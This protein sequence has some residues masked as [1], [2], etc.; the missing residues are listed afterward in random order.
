VTAGFAIAAG[1]GLGLLAL[2]T[3]L[4]VLLGWFGAWRI[5]R[6]PSSRPDANF[7]FTPWE[8]DLEFSPVH[9]KTA[10]DVRLHGWFLPRPDS[11]RVIIVM[12]GYRG[13]KAQL[14]GISSY[15]WRAGFN[16]LLFD[17]RGRGTSD[18]ANISM[19]LWEQEDLKAA[20]EVADQ[21]VPRAA[22]GLLGYSMGGVVALMGGSDP[23]VG[24]IAVDS[25]FASQRTMLEHVARQESRQY[26]RGWLDGRVFLSA[27][28]WWHRRWGKPPFSAIAPESV[29]PQLTDKPVL[30]IHGSQDA[31]IPREHAERLVS[32]APEKH[33]VWFVKGAHHCGA[34]FTDRPAYSAR[35]AAFFNRHLGSSSVSREASE[36]DRVETA[37][38]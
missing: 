5:N 15:L 10:D 26:L 8:L 11:R 22:I 30:V 3:G 28:E 37:S 2:A 13:H 19:G 7:A 4:W 12:H 24:A 38:H 23:R 14:L 20:L 34:Y 6:P 9:F 29:M 32:I 31:L 25:A 1:V 17:F 16:V 27:V 21:Q 36:L 18:R 35:V 33:E